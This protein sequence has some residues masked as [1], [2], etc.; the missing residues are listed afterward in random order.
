MSQLLSI[1]F[2]FAL[3]I[4]LIIP[5]HADIELLQKPPKCTLKGWGLFIGYFGTS[6]HN[7]F[8]KPVKKDKPYVS[9]S[10][11]NNRS[12]LYGELWEKIPYEGI[13]FE[14]GIN[15]LFLENPDGILLAYSPSKLELEKDLKDSSFTNFGIFHLGDDCYYLYDSEG[16][17]IKKLDEQIRFSIKNILSKIKAP[18]IDLLIGV[19]NEVDLAGKISEDKTLAKNIL[20]VVRKNRFYR[21]SYLKKL[22]NKKVK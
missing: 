7:I 20:R 14:P 19:E 11:I 18:T 4:G 9:I 22:E 16:K 10:L 8:C 17:N 21:Y 6:N 1:T 2:V 12:V 3:L 5:T 13:D 15:N